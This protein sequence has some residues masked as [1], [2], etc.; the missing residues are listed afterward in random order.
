ME[1]LTMERMNKF[2][3]FLD[4]LIS[5]HFIKYAIVGGGRSFN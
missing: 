2:H 4:S 1:D 3:V 5:R